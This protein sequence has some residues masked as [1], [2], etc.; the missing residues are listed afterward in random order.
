MPLSFLQ[1]FMYRKEDGTK[2]RML[3]HIQVWS[4]IFLRY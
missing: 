1:I 2:E 3:D 4:N